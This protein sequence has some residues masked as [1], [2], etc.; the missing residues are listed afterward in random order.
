MGLPLTS[1]SRLLLK[2][3][4]DFQAKGHFHRITRYT[5][6]SS[7]QHLVLYPLSF[8]TL[9]LSECEEEPPF[10]IG[11]NSFRCPT[12]F[13]PSPSALY[14]S[15]LR[16][17]LQYPRHCS[18]MTVLRSDLSELIGYDLLELAEGYVDPDDDEA[19]HE[20]EVDKRLMRAAQIVK[21]WGPQAWRKGEDWMA[22]ALSAVAAG[23]GS[24]EYLPHRE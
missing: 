16:L 19:W 24:I 20:K 13:V 18:T 12:I 9:D 21:S 1:P 15:I 2:R 23:S 7:V 8:S 11:S 6:P 22:D 5:A 4:G 17:M 10:H 3:E 14:A